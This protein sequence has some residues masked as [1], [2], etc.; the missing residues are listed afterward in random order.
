MLESKP[1]IIKIRRGINGFKYSACNE[2]GYFLGNF[3]KLADVRKHWK[4]EIK[5]GQVEL[6]REL[7]LMPDMSRLNATMAAIEKILE[8]YVTQPSKTGEKAH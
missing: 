5:W 4:T 3:E 7:H 1:T 6:V 2:Q 8:T